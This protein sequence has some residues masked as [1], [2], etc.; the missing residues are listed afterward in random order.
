MR[1]IKLLDRTINLRISGRTLNELKD[2]SSAK[3]IPVSELIRKA[4]KD[5]YSI[6]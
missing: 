4:V 2:I 1:T 5:T 6:N 3:N